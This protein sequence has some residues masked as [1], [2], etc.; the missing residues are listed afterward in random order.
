MHL[1]RSELFPTG[2][3][4]RAGDDHA[5]CGELV[6]QRRRRVGEAF[7][8]QGHNPDTYLPFSVPGFGLLF[9][10]VALMMIAR[11]PP[12]CW[13]VPSSATAICFSAGCRW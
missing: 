6:R 11:S 5:L 13:A 1:L 7:R 8:S 9:A 3:G 12:T 4:R 2:A 10:I